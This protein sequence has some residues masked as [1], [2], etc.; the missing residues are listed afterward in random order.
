[1]NVRI[2]GI[3]DHST[4]SPLPETTLLESWQH[5][6][7]HRWID[8]ES[9]TPD[10][11]RQ[12]LAPLGLHSTILESCLQSDR[13]ARF[14]SHRSALYLEIPTHHGWE[15]SEKPYVSVLCL[16]T[17]IITIHRDNL[18]TIEDIIRGL[19]AEVPLYA[20]HSSAL[21]YY[22]LVEIGTCTVDAALDV[23]D[24]AVRMDR[25]SHGRPEELDPQEI[26]TLRRRI[27]H[28]STVHDDHVY[29][30]GVLQSVESDA[31]RFSEQAKCFHDLLRLSELAR[32]LIGGA[33]S[34]VESLQHEYEL[35]VHDRVENRLRFLTILSAVLLPLTLI[36]AVYGMNFNNL[37]AMGMPYGYLIVIGL[38]AATAV[39][40]G[41]LL[42]VR[43]WF[44]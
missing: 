27:N 16:N 23:R 40:T 12:L 28:Y 33:E 21:L 35:S 44:E 26:A 19:D 4:L 13:S 34:R 41:G 9:A 24:E 10:E 22:L 31:F 43:G 20:A 5:D 1:M 29:C 37:P 42:Y 7:T 15:Q 14:I 3:S 39:I 36:S 25:L 2:F 17:T 18:H 30:V 6:A 11:I 38:M 8:I 32:Q